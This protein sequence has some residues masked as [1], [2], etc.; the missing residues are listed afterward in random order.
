LAR[1]AGAAR[2]VSPQVKNLAEANIT[3]NGDTV[4]GHWG[5]INKARAKGASYFDIGNAW[6]CAYACSTNGG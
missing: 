3:K 4:L 6:N 2:G 1:G 5:Y